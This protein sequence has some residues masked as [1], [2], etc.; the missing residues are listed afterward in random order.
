MA[1]DTAIGP[2][3]NLLEPTPA[4]ARQISLPTPVLR[5]EEL[6]KLRNLDGGGGSHGF[7]SINA[8][9]AVRRG[10][11]RRRAA[12]RRSRPARGG[13][14][15]DRRRE[16]HHHPLRP[17]A[18]RQAGA[19]PGA[20]GRRGR[21]STTSCARARARGSAWSSRRGEPREVHHFALLLGY[22][23]SAINPYLALE[24]AARHG[25][26]GP[27]AGRRREGR[28]EVRQGGRQ[29]DRQG[30]LEDGDLDHPELPRRAG[31][32]GHRPQPAA[33][34]TSTSPGPP[35][36]SSG[37]GID[38]IADEVRQR[39]LRAFP[40]RPLP[41]DSLDAGGQYQYRRSGEYHLFNPSHHP[42]AAAGLPHR[43]LRHVQGVLH[44]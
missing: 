33:S 28:A 16:Q 15:G 1:V 11:G 8:A 31:L 43:R 38:E 25:Q 3:G 26:A 30:L 19:D 44:A 41:A 7:R 36:A 21:C 32:R 10:G 40:E 4:S 9:D 12:R 24:I 39:H 23:A 5:N 13:Q 14:Q 22:G 27:L 2:E 18:R 6:E 29:G 35:R 20:A 34:S 42:Q 17:R 37:I